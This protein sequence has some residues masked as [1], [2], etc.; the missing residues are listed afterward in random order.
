MQSE[1][2]TQANE[3]SADTTVISTDTANVAT[4][5]LETDF[6]KEQPIE[7]VPYSRLRISPMNAR[8]KPL[9]GI[10]GLAANIS[11]KG[12]LQNLVV[13]LIKGSRSKQPKLGV[14]AG[15]R[16]LAA[17]D[18]LYKDGRIAADYPVPVRIVSEAEAFAVS[19]IENSQR[20]ALDVFDLI[21]SFKRLANEGKRIDY[22][23]ALFS[24]SP[25]TVKRRL[26]LADVSPKL[27]ALLR[28]DDAITLDQLAAL[29]LVDD[30]ETQERLWFDA[31]NEWQRAPHYL[32]QA[33][34]RAEID[35]SRSRLVK[36]VGLEAYEAA[37]GYVRRDLFSDEQNAGF[38]ADA[39]L[40]QRL[41][42]ERLDAAAEEVR[43]EGFGWIETRIERDYSELNFF[44]RLEPVQRPYTDNEQRELDALNMQR[45]GLAAQ[46]DALD[47]GDEDAYEKAER[48]ETALDAANTAIDNFA[49]RAEMWDV[50]QIAE[51]GALVMVG[52]NGELMIERGLVRPESKAAL[53]EHGAIVSGLADASDASIST[54]TATP[55]ERPIHSAALCQRLTAH[56]TAAVQ[57]ELTKRPSVAL[58]VLLHRLLP[59]TF[60]KRYGQGVEANS[61]QINGTCTYDK[62]TS[63]ADDMPASVAWSIIDAQRQQWAATL[64]S[65][66]TDL[67][68]WLIEQDPGTTLLDLL[69]FCTTSLVDGISGTE[70]PHAVNT[71][72][73]VLELDMTHYWIPTRASYFDHVSKARIIEVVTNAVSPKAAADLQKMKK[74]DAA[75]AAELRLAQVKWLPEILTDQALPTVNYFDPESEDEERDESDRSDDDAENGDP[76]GVA[77]EGH[78]APDDANGVNGPDGADDTDP[79]AA[80]T[81]AGNGESVPAVVAATPA[82]PFPTAASAEAQQRTR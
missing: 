72:S 58:A 16:R 68:P 30:H 25:L 31:P 46:F 29:A 6:G 5:V 54:G 26:K 52:P 20:E 43:A 47:E 40:L 76:G 51:A 56:R 38:V 12:L 80:N 37:G 78:G 11:A 74:G 48:L 10:A 69:A 64:P 61:V 36:F 59:I 45:D 60:P 75:A 49:K 24:V 63:A 57:A 7:H 44:G 39:E 21:G 32:H 28:E 34:T 62:L 53:E 71:I 1:I 2:T 17:L 67:L 77:P 8:T 3:V 14:C 65:R 73:N 4:S 9:T 23:A 35:A 33:I 70:R 42:S 66:R 55:K 19:L 82:W 22:I 41:V 13:H 27:L 50:Q 15:Q 79:S 18:L 81:I